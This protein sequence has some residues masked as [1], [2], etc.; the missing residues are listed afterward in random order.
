MQPV[1]LHVL[2]RRGVGHRLKLWWNAE[3][4]MLTLAG[5]L[6]DVEV[7]G[8]LMFDAPQRLGDLAEVEWRLTNSCSDAP[9]VPRS[10]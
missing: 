9:Q 5:Q 2:Q 8:I 7:V 1:R 3:T 6:L 4:L 10:T